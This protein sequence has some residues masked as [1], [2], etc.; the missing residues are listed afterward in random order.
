MD[1]STNTYGTA[2]WITNFQ[3]FGNGGYGINVNNLGLSLNNFYLNNDYAGEIYIA[4][5]CQTVNLT[6]GQ[7]QF[8]GLSPYYGTNTS[9]NGITIEA[10][11]LQ[12]AEITSVQFFNNQGSDIV[13]YS[14]S[15]QL[16]IT[17]CAF[18]GS[19]QGGVVGS[20]YAINSAQPYTRITNVF[21]GAPINLSGKNSTI[22]TS[23]IFGNSSTVPA[24]SISGGVNSAITGVFVYQNGSGGTA[25]QSA[26][27]TS[28]AVA[29]S[30][31]VG[32]I[33]TAEAGTRI[34]AG[35]AYS[36]QNVVG[37]TVAATTG[38]FSTIL[39]GP[40]PVASI[41]AVGNTVLL[42]GQ[43]LSGNI[44]RGGSTAA[45]TDT[46]DTAANIVASIL[47]AVAGVG[48]GLTIA[49]NTAYQCTLA[50]GT[51]VTLAGNTAIAPS[52]SRKYVVTITNVASPAVTITGI[53]SGGL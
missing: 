27:G 50:A 47:N 31:F 37:G 19:G 15:G 32:P 40:K 28:Y 52:S 13:D 46:T 8:A 5:T 18:E 12:D 1:R 9:A 7:I 23:F 6:N 43:M 14:I 22:S 38:V 53:S 42:A 3:S 34:Y 39:A 24:L 16:G 21:A 10:G 51:G 30:Q 36:A 44:L 26:S 45:Y 4:S 2:P 11:F 29:A 41:S 20:T 33:N 49:N 25:F 17:A 48:Y 35:N